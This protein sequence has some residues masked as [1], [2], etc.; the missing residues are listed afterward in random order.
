MLKRE[1]IVTADGSSTIYIPEWNEHYHSKH[2]AI[3]EA[4]YVYLDKGLKHFIESNTSV[5][6]ISILEIGFGTGLNAFL[7]YLQT[8]TFSGE[9]D[10][11][12]I[13]AFPVTNDELQTLKYPELLNEVS[14]SET[15][16]KL[17]SC[18][19]ETKERISDTFSLTKQLKM[20]D[21]IDAKNSY[22][23]VYFDAFGPRVQPE[24]WQASI[25]EKIHKAMKP[26]GVLTTYC[27]KGDVRRTLIEVGFTV[28]RLDGP[29]GKRHMLRA[30][31]R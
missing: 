7:T 4:N 6:T 2:G 12:A 25:F 23:V 1:V 19:W 26:K 28:E 20:F 21:K 15:F 13:E 8:K 14:E 29:P 27:A 31:K 17:H 16:N 9:I 24:L 22:D 18:N 5:T 11:T 3:Q 10:Y 30:E